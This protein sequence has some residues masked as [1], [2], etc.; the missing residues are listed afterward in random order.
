[1]VQSPIISNYEYF[2]RIICTEYFNCKSMINEIVLCIFFLLNIDK[3]RYA[4]NDDLIMPR[5]RND[6]FALID[7]VRL[8][9]LSLYLNN[10]VERFTN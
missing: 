8:A 3:M 10:M 9:I 5:P 1:M 6:K 7:E 4:F 2:S